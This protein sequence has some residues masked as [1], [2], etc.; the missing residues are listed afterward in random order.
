MKRITFAI[1]FLTATAGV[2][3]AAWQSR[4]TAAQA[5]A[6]PA[7]TGIVTGVILSDTND[8]QPIRRAAVRLSGDSG[9][10]SRIVGTD[11]DGRFVFDQLRAGRF[12]LSASKAGFVQ[13]FHGSTQPGRG[14]GVPV[15]VTDGARVEVSIRMLPGAAIA[16]IITD[17]HGNPAPGTTVMVVDTRASGA[18][19]GRSGGPFRPADRVVTDDRGAFRVF[20]LAPGEY[21]VSALPNLL[22]FSRFGAG[23]GNTQVTAVTDADVASAKAGVAGATAGAGGGPP[24]PTRPV[25]YAPI[26]YPGT[27]DAAAAATIRVSTGE[28]RVG[29]NLVL[30]IVTLARLSGTI[31]DRTGNAVTNASVLLVPKRGDR[32]TPADA[33]VASGAA[34]MPRATVSASG[35]V[36][37]GVAPGQYTLIARTGGGQRGLATAGPGDPTQWSVMDLSVDGNDR[38]DLALRLQPGLKVTG[39]LT[40]DGASPQPK[41]S[42]AINLSFVAINPFPGVTSVYRAAVQAD[43]TFQIPSL[44]PGQYLVRID[45]LAASATARW[46]LKS[47]IVNERDLADRPLTATADGSELAGIVVTLTDRAAEISG[48]LIDASGRPVT[49][50]SIVVFTQD[51]SLWLPGA[52]RIHAVRP[53][54]DGSFAVTGLP[55]GDYAIAAVENAEDA[56]LSDAG[57]LSQLL[58]SALKLTIAEGDRRRQD[59]KVGR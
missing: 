58:A 49:R 55:A 46:A 43:G 29:V 20:G 24:G 27:T 12:T 8:P 34:L 19:I 21:L 11:D 32:P 7:G 23:T 6:A 54:T 35:F 42:A 15:A 16:G 4:D 39:R 40:F 33:L 52:R 10:S 36:F 2:A 57:F 22:P 45:P 37:L 31:A 48:R 28:E 13:T 30:Q 1:L 17:A 56:D 50:Y 5:V 26:F 14:P 47:A 18:G 9:T 53:A 3:M 25:A 41:D 38:S 44:G 51:Q 59:L